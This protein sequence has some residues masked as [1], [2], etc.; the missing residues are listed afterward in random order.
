MEGIIR[1]HGKGI[2]KNEKKKERLRR[3]RGMRKKKRTRR[4]G[5]AS[6]K[7]TEYKSKR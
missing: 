1:E 2:K 4:E 7:I 6:E 5:E 3:K